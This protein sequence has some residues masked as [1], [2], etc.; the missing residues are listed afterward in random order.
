M[1][2]RSVSCNFLMLPLSAC[3]F[4][5]L[6]IMS[7]SN[8]FFLFVC[9][10]GGGGKTPNVKLRGIMFSWGLGGVLELYIHFV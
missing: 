9:A 10:G 2:L 4:S 6:K 5:V 3:D 1:Y 8:F 7:Y